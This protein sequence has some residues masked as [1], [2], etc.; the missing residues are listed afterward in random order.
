MVEQK[1]MSPF[2]AFFLGLFG[3]SGLLVAGVTVLAL[4]GMSIADN[5][6]TQ[7]LGFADRT[8]AGLPELIERLPES[9]QEILNDR[10]APEYTSNVIVESQF[11]STGYKNQV[12]PT[13]TITNNGDE[14][15]SLMAVRVAA[16]NDHN[17][18]YCDWSE[19]VAT[20]IALDDNDWPGPI[21]PRETRHIVLSSWCGRHSLTNLP[22]A[23]DVEIAELRVWEPKARVAKVSSH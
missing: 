1:R 8:V 12:V 18:P 6:V 7:V 13:L 4:R 17:A 5:N 22:A 21:F 14:I 16:L 19:V 3:V 23:G 20:P 9:V 10:R 2:T 15:I 11:V